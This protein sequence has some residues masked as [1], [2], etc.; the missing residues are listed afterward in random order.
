MAHSIQTLR[1]SLL[2]LLTFTSLLSLTGCVGI[3][4]IDSGH[5]GVLKKFGKVDQES[6]GEGIHFYNPVTSDVIEMNVQENK[7]EDSTTT[8]T[9][10]TQK[11]HI[12]YVL[13]FYPEASR[14]PIFY[15][16]YGLEWRNKLIPQATLGSIKDIIGKINA[17]EINGARDKTARNIES[18]LKEKL[19]VV[20]VFVRGFE[21]TNIQFEPEYE[22]AVEAKVIA[23]QKAVEAQN[24]TAEVKEQAAQQMIAAHAQAE[25]MKIRS[26]ALVKN[27][28]LI[29]YEAVQ[30]WDGKLPNIMLSGK[31]IPFLSLKEKD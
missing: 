15:Q 18:E 20:G 16:Q 21:I 19:A 9:R 26:E 23:T 4:I 5:R 17:D 24:R 22:K 31:S 30:K 13:N 12:T 14:M 8:Y 27:K 7:F 3:A 10:D 6:L 2:S 1:S 28:S 11:T 29:E 25:S